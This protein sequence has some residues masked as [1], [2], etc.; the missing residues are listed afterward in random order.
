MKRAFTYDQSR[1]IYREHIAGASVKALAERYGVARTAIVS[2]FA[3]VG[4]KQRN[5]SGAM[6]LRMSRTSAAERAALSKAAHDAV[7]GS[8]VSEDALARKARSRQG[9]AISVYETIVHDALAAAGISAV[10]NY[11]VGKYMIDVAIHDRFFAVEIDGGGWHAVP[12]KR[13]A[14]AVKD[15]YLRAHGWRVIRLGGCTQHRFR[16]HAV[17]LIR[18]FQGRGP[19][20]PIKRINGVVSGDPEYPMPGPN[21]PKM[22]RNFALHEA[23][24]RAPASQMSPN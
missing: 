20:P 19:R 14:D 18:Y 3:R 6:Y 16:I 23:N 10:L 2:G 12:K 24:D 11:A 22:L 8:K 1:K 13:A 4:L 17:D 9:R 5:R 15:A 21:R 7:R